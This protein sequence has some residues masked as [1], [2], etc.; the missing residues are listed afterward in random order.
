MAAFRRVDSELKFAGAVIDV[1]N[2]RFETPTGELIDRD[3][4]HHPGAVS[5]VPLHDDNT[6]TVVRQFRAA[7]EREILEIPAGKRDVEGELLEAVAQ[8][9]LQEEVGLRAKELRKLISLEHSPGFCDEVNHIY[10]ATGLMPVARSTDGAEEDYMTIHRIPLGDVFDLIAR[11]EIADA[12][13][14]AG[15]LL[16]HHVVFG[17]V[18]R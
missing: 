8:R 13:S 6:V 17:D 1:Y 5:V 4:V 14:V 16:A 9:E 18:T 10:L 2:V 11:G 12:K 3:V 15:L 7:F